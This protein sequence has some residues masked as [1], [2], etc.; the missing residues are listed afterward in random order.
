[1]TTNCE[2]SHQLGEIFSIIQENEKIANMEKPRKSDGA[3]NP[4][5]LLE[6]QSCLVTFC[7]R[8]CTLGRIE[9]GVDISE[10]VMAETISNVAS[11]PIVEKCSVQVRE[12]T[13]ELSPVLRQVCPQVVYWTAGLY[14]CACQ[15]RRIIENRNKTKQC[16]LL[17]HFEIWPPCESTSYHLCG[18]RLLSILWIICFFFLQLSA[19]EGIVD[20]IPKF[21][22]TLLCFRAICQKQTS[23]LCTII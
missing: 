20:F 9:Q 22:M 10:K 13:K 1:M 17:E 14:Y 8:A 5:S 18:K 16:K 19:A 11:F 12:Q 4:Y 23:S 3:V 2:K 6:Y 21:I 15:C 7:P